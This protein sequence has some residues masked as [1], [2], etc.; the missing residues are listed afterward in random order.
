MA[1]IVKVDGA[2]KVD[3]AAI[4]KEEEAGK[5]AMAEGI[6]KVNTAEIVKV[7]EAAKAVM[8]EIVK[9][10]E[11]AKAVMAEIV[12]VD[13]AAKAVIVAT[14]KEA[15]AEKAVMA[16]IVKVDGAA[17]GK[18]AAE[19]M[20]KAETAE[21]ADTEPSPEGAEASTGTAQRNIPVMIRGGQGKNQETSLGQGLTAPD[22]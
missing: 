5:A 19:E 8:A 2:A 1:E 7:E 22:S 20:V 4:G 11:A 15:E 16:E 18:G 14:G 12:K 21:V 3:T 13:G 17:T 9:V 6:V 10:E